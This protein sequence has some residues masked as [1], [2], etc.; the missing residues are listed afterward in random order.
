MTFFTPY[1]LQK[2]SV[3]NVKKKF[4]RILSE[5]EKAKEPNMGLK[6]FET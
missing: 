1:I 4:T 2:R 3:K 5:K 6:G